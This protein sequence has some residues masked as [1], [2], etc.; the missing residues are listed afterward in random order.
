[1]NDETPS[2]GISH[3]I[4]I[5]LI[6][7]FLFY[8]GGRAYLLSITHDEA[9]T[10]LSHAS[11]SF[12][13]I[14]KD[15]GLFKSNNHLINTVLIKIFVNIFGLS[16]FVVR[17][18]AL[19]GFA[20]YLVSSLKILRLFLKGALGTVGL[21]LLALNPFMID[22][23][24]CAR[25][26]SLGL[27]FMSLGVYY[28]FKNGGCRPSEMR[29]RYSLISLAMLALA[30]LSNLAFLNILIPA[31]IIMVAMETLSSGIVFLK[32]SFILVSSVAFFLFLIYLS[33][34][35]AM[36]AEGAF[37]Y[38]GVTGFWQDTVATLIEVTCYDKISFNGLSLLFAK[39]FII[40]VISLTGII[41]YDSLKKRSRLPVDRYLFLAFALTILSACVISAQHALMGTKYVIDRS[42]IYFIPLFSILL[43]LLAAKTKTFVTL[44][45]Y[46]IFFAFIVHYLACAN[47]S[48]FL[49]WKYDAS[50]KEAVNEL[51][52]ENAGKKLP[53]RSVRIA[54]DWIFEP[55]VN[56][57]IAKEGLDWLQSPARLSPNI[58]SDYYYVVDREKNHKAVQ[59]F[60][61]EDFKPNRGPVKIVKRYDLA[62]TFLAGAAPSSTK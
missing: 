12:G 39:L 56:F 22:L 7:A 33:G 45:F 8:A 37:C 31:L 32:R 44:L 59:E 21:A 18:P 40:G 38:G 29:F 61:L 50:T 60:Y 55:S 17:I 57:Y 13:D 3:K 2:D 47:I 42:A 10:F 1:M 26:Y 14:F 35:K 48:Y 27:G 15:T 51:I 34:I 28:L 53:A 5:I 24:S 11:R 4:S 49:L 20:L 52:K 19:L 30:S 58:K 54:T 6:G 43:L 25:G 16:E 41:L 62:G 46:G 36:L 9:L 23:F